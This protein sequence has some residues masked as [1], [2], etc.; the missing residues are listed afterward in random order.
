MP[1]TLA[2]LEQELAWLQR[3]VEASR[4][5]ARQ[6]EAAVRA[7]AQ[8]RGKELSGAALGADER[9]RA[10]RRKH[11]R[12]SRRMVALDAAEKAGR[13]IWAAAQR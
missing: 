11:S 2:D 10:A 9:V 5:E 4:R 7:R 3:K 6:E 8:Q 1:E 13:A 12:Y